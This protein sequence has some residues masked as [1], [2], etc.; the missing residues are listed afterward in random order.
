MNRSMW[1]QKLIGLIWTVTLLVAAQFIAA[2]AFAHGAH[3]NHGPLPAAERVSTSEGV[4]ATPHLAAEL[5]S[6]TDKAPGSTTA[7]VCTG[8][9]CGTGS[10]CGG[11]ALFAEAQAPV[12]GDSLAIKVPATADHPPGREPDGLIRPPR[13]LA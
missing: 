11:A 5:A 1:K 8:G 6:A 10:G 9:C 7:G 12:P 4:A 13:L 2:S 3:A